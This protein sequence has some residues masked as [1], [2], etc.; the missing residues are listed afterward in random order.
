VVIGWAYFE[1][2]RLVPEA[3]L[4]KSLGIDLRASGDKAWNKGA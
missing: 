4:L 2:W 1:G 3:P